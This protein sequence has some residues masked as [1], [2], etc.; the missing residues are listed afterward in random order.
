MLS[1]RN[2]LVQKM[3]STEIFGISQTLPK[4]RL[5]L[6]HGTISS[7]VKQFN[8]CPKPIIPSTENAIV[9][10]LSA[11]TCMNIPS[12]VK[13][14]ND[15]AR[16]IYGEIIVFAE[17]FQRCDAVADQY[18]KTSL[19][20][21]I[22]NVGGTGIIKLFNENTDIPAHFIEGFLMNNHNKRNLNLFLA[23]KMLLLHGCN[24]NICVTYNDTII[25]N[26]ENVLSE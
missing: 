7:I 10:E 23:E 26:D 12:W 25:S 15:Y 11:M 2:E 20:E 24:T 6:Y 16:F 17:E 18:F 4:N 19:K 22:R 1:Y 13:T 3:F 9:I 21:K 8:T 14:F 5:S